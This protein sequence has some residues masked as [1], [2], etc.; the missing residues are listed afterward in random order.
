MKLV[1]LSDSY[2]LISQEEFSVVTR[3]NFPLINFIP[4]DLVTAYSTSISEMLLSHDTYTF[5]MC[6]HL[7]KKIFCSKAVKKDSVQFEF[8]LKF[9]IHQIML[10]LA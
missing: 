7:L 1:L 3:P 10:Q 4:L 8:Q 6:S 9:L 2:K 5:F